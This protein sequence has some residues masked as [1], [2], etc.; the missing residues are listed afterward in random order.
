M[1]KI[2]GKESNFSDY[3]RIRI[4]GGKGGDGC[5]AF[6]KTL[7]ALNGPPAGG[8]GGKGGNVYVE[9]CQK[10]SSL[11]QLKDIYAVQNGGNGKGKNIHGENGQNITIK[12]PVG[13]VVRQIKEIPKAK[14]EAPAADL[15]QDSRLE[16]LKKFFKFR[17]GYTPLEDRIQMLME[18]IPVR[19][20]KK[21]LIELDLDKEGKSHL[22]FKGGN[23]GYGNPQ[24]QSYGNT[25]PPFAGLGEAVSPIYLEFELKTLADI[26]LVGLPNAGK[27]TLLTAVSN[28]HPKIAPYPFTTLNPYIGTIEYPDYWN[29]KLAD[30]PGIVKGAHQ[31]MGLGLRFLR[32]IERNHVFVY[33]IDLAGAAPW[34]DLATLQNELEQYKESLTK[35]KE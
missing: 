31:N 21:E 29:L 11:F 32:H 3:R 24:F 5:I 8:N 20:Q 15:E 14:V 35:M 19:T 33:V 4:R 7:S 22:I 17:T 13:T 34:D 1:F 26:G 28:A 27:S 25:S 23:G 16:S 2:L 18:R 6:N 12:V 10:V 30:M 9:A